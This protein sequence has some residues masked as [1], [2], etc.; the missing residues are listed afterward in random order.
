MWRTFLSSINLTLVLSG[1]AVAFGCATGAAQAVKLDD[2]QL[3]AL[4]RDVSIETDPVTYDAT[5][6]FYAD[7][8]YHVDG[9]GGVVGTYVVASSRVC[10]TRP[11]LGAPPS[12]RCR[13]IFRDGA[14][15]LFFTDA[16][17][18]ALQRSTPFHVVP[19]QR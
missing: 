8:E 18:F 9:R 11:E 15:N 1:L 7:G 4:L 3:T 19:V 16:E 14:G 12:T 6:V 2:V 17:P 5:E 10:V 13:M